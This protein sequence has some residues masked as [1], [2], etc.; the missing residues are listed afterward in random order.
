MEVTFSDSYVGRSY[1]YLRTGQ[2]QLAIKDLNMA[3]QLDQNIT[4]Y[5]LRGHLYEHLN[6]Y[7]EAI[8]DY[9]RVIDDF[10]LSRIK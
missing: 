2:F 1:C 3:I 4:A 10:S 8:R 6:L 9:T 7:E 5:F